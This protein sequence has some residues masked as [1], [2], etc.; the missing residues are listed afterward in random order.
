MYV[1]NDCPPF[2]KK[3]MPALGPLRVLWTVEVTMSQCSKGEGAS[4]VATRPLT[5]AM[6]AINSDPHESAI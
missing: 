3:M 2:L 1:L 5:C 4:P 6:S